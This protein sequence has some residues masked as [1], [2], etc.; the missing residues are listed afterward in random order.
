ML[1]V[2]LSAEALIPYLD[3]ELDL[4]SDN[5]PK[6][7]V[8]SGPDA[9]LAQLAERLKADGIDSQRVPINIAAHSRMLAPILADF[10]AYLRG[11][12]LHAP[13]IPIVS[14]RSGTWL[15]AA[16]AQDPEYWVNHL[17]Q[18][19]RFRAGLTTLSTDQNRIY[20]EVGP[21]RAL[22]S[23]AGQHGSLP[24]IRWSIR[25]ATRPKKPATMPISCRS[26][27]ASGLWA[28]PLTGVRSGVCAAQPRP[29]AHI[30]VS[31][32]RAFH[33]TGA[34]AK[35][36]EPWLTR[37]ADLAQW[38]YVPSWTPAYAACEVDVTA[39]WPRHPGKPGSSLPTIRA[40]PLAQPSGCA[41]RHAVALVR[42]RRLRRDGDDYV[43]GPER[44]RE[45]YD[46]LLRDLAGRGLAPHESGISGWLTKDRKARPDPRSFTA[47]R[48][49]GFWSLFYLRAGAWG[50]G[51]G[52]RSSPYSP[53]GWS[54]S[55]PRVCPSPRNRRPGAGAGYPRESSGPWRQPAG[56]GPWRRSPGRNSGRTA[57]PP[58]NAVAALRDGKRF[59]RGLRAETLPETPFRVTQGAPVMIT[60]GFGGIGLTVAEEMI[61]RHATPVALIARTPLPPREHGNGI[62]GVLPM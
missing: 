23:L 13:T 49:Q 19:V 55:G 54:V 27:G 32:A 58:G 53:T 2:P 11:I 62:C 15:T 4:A 17:R 1:S 36:A 7:S 34:A 10:G 56:F 47:F 26:W 51:V 41:G 42:A 46:R 8:A 12:A 9:A 28:G 21:G 37:T 14:N 25:C 22:A 3:G 29:P 40:W 20:I 60:G 5:A 43:M 33:R 16:E 6:L 39:I 45:G 52:H 61:R 18:T 38:G 48:K 31:N 59:L 30:S 50:R 57:G 44:G 35:P 24:P